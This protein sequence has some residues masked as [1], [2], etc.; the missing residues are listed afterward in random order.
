M[1]CKKNLTREQIMVELAKD[2]IGSCNSCDNLVYANG[3]LMCRMLS[4]NDESKRESDK[5]D[6]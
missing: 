4:S 2:D 3:I 5:Y 6:H 1:E